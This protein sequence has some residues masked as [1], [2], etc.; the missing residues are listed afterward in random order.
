MARPTYAIFKGNKL[1]DQGYRTYEEARQQVRKFLRINRVTNF[2]A[3]T[4]T[5]TSNANI[6]YAGY[7][8]RAAESY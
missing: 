8:I 6:G 2:M 4:N 1:A 5:D 3:F 7:S